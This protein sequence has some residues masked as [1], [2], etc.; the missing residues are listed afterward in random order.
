MST[1]R[2]MELHVVK[3]SSVRVYATRRN[4]SSRRVHA[5]SVCMRGRD[6]HQHIVLVLSRAPLCGEMGIM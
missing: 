1:A 4:V 2:P 6:G 3:C 5:A